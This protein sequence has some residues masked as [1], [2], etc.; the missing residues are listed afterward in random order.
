MSDHAYSTHRDGI[1]VTV[2]P[3]DKLCAILKEK[4]L[5]Q[6]EDNERLKQKIKDLESGVFAEEEMAKMKLNYE[7]MKKD[8]YRGF[9]ISEK[10]MDNIR[11]WIGEHEK[12]HPG[13]HGAVSGKYTYEFTPTGIGTF[14]CVKC[15]CGKKFTFQDAV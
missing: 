10:E 11:K 3:I 6:E 13:G 4:F 8:Y 2:P 1:Y 14:G 12:E 7:S 9:P 5:R 15:S